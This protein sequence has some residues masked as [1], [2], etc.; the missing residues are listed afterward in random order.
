M[1]PGYS[2]V[3]IV[4]MVLPDENVAL[5]ASEMDFYM[6]FMHN[7]S[8]RSEK[9]WRVLIEGAGLELIK[10]WY[11]NDSGDGVIEVQRGFV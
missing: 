9:E 3:I 5:R 1:T 11:P 2:K 7:G 8:Q 4:D 6:I 10:I